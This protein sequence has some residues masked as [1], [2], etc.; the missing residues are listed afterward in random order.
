MDVQK[1][2]HEEYFDDMVV[3]TFDEVLRIDDGA[4]QGTV[5]KQDGCDYKVTAYATKTLKT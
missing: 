3:S 1:D 4:D 5:L 2:F